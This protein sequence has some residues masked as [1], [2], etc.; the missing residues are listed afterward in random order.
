MCKLIP[1]QHADVTKRLMARVQQPDLHLL[2]RKNIGSHL[3]A[4]SFPL[5]PS[6]R[7]MIF[8]NPLLEWFRHHR[9]A[10]LNSEFFLDKRSMHVGRGRRNSIDHAVW[11][12]PVLL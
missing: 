3:R 7:E 11:K 8:N 10:I 6:E 5:R 9:P 4:Y 1:Q 2:V 12:R